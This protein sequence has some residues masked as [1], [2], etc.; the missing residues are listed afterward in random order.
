MKKIQEIKW[1]YLHRFIFPEDLR[2]PQYFLMEKGGAGAC[3]FANIIGLTQ[4]ARTKY[5]GLIAYTAAIISYN[6]RCWEF[7]GQGA[8][9]FSFM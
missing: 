3:V 1:F 5:P 9:P 4:A 2:H 8:G 6:S 7:Q